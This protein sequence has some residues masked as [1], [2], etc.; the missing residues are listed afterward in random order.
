MCYF[1]SILLGLLSLISLSLFA[2]GSEEATSVRSTSL[3]HV[4][5]L[6]TDLIDEFHVADQWVV[7]ELRKGSDNSILRKDSMPT[8]QNG[9]FIFTYKPGQ[10]D[11]QEEYFFYTISTF[12][13]CYGQV[14]SYDGELDAFHE[15]SLE[16]VVCTNCD[17]VGLINEIDLSRVTFNLDFDQS[18]SFDFIQ[19]NFGDDFVTYNET[20]TEHYYESAGKYEVCVRYETIYGC[21]DEICTTIQIDQKAIDNQDIH[22]IG[23][24]NNSQAENFEFIQ[25]DNGNSI[26]LIMK[27]ILDDDTEGGSSNS[28]QL[29]KNYSVEIISIS[30]QSMYKVVSSN[31][32]LDLPKFNSGMYYIVIKDFSNQKISSLP[33]I[34]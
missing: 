2:G 33:I 26:T 31:N 34:F 3:V 12:D 1:K 14:V 18:L 13:F 30:G 10:I 17:E 32:V 20:T 7:L 6:V 29:N 8:N 25:F 27:E 4:S 15:E 24:G 22:N 5:G 19:W 11:D 23:I 21:Y 9:E 28:D 16:L